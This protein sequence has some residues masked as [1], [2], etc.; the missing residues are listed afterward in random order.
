M[1]EAELEDTVRDT[2]E[3]ESYDQIEPRDGGKKLGLAKSTVSS[4]PPKAR[5]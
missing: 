3:W 1:I 2:T 5:D 4:L